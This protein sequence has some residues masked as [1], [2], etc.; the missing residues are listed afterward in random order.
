MKIALVIPTYKPHFIYLKQLCKNISEQTRLPDLVIIRASSCDTPEAKAILQQLSERPLPFSLQILDTAEPQCQAQNRN[1]GADAV[2]PE[3]DAVSF[4]DSDDRMHPRR[5]EFIEAMFA[6]GAEGVIHSYKIGTEASEPP[7]DSFDTLPPHVWGS[8][9]LQKESAIQTGNQIVS[10]SEI[11]KIFPGWRPDGKEI[12]F[13]RAIPMNEDLD[14]QLCAQC[15]HLSVLLH[16]FKGLRFDEEALGYED[17]KYVS[18][19]VMREH[20]TVTITGILSYYT[21]RSNNAS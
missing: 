15:G 8:I 2:P 12:T 4:F 16:V 6:Q 13:F 10:L 11:K 21:M 9:L 5:L 17:I 14:E 20:K 1:E 7:W 18:E 19:L 3:F